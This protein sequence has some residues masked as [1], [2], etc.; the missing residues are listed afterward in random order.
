MSNELNI[1]NNHGVFVKNF[2]VTEIKAGD[3]VKST[4]DLPTSNDADD[5]IFNSKLVGDNVYSLGYKKESS[6]GIYKN[7]TSSGG[8]ARFSTYNLCNYFEFNL[9]GTVKSL[10]FTPTY[11]TR[12][13]LYNG[14]GAKETEDAD[15]KR[16]TY[17]NIGIYRTSRMYYFKVWGSSTSD[18]Y[19]T[20]LYYGVTSINETY[21]LSIKVGIARENDSYK[22][23]V[24]VPHYE[25]G[26]DTADI[27]TISF[28]FTPK[29][30]VAPAFLAQ[31]DS[32]LPDNLEIFVLPIIN[33][34]FKVLT[35]WP[36]IKEEIYEINRK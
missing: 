15:T 13:C 28:N 9:V 17:V 35:E 16:G 10:S 25:I 32:E 26:A 14:L 24:K 3:V 22:V 23:T 8:F 11:M 2:F 27:K 21:T 29:S 30:P 31:I 18:V 19:Y 7:G 5:I 1:I 33:T 12:I 34:S 36:L 4:F 6:Y 20:S